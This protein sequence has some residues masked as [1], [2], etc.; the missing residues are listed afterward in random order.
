MLFDHLV[1]AGEQRRW[2]YDAQGLGG[3]QIDNE[4]KFGWLLNR[5]VGC[6]LAL[7]DAVNVRGDPAAD[8]VSRGP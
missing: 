3:P 7:K 6:F 1:G 5:Q 8:F 2:H 4:L